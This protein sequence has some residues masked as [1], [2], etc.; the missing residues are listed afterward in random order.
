MNSGQG[1]RPVLVQRQLCVFASS[2]VLP[3]NP[4]NIG[5]DPDYATTSGCID[6]DPDTVFVPEIP[7]L[8]QSRLQKRL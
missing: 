2:S 6:T 8:G 1:S 5:L 7:G 3:G 4:R